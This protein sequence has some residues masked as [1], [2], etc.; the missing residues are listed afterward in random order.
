[1]HS[2]SNHASV[3]IG[4]VN[5]IGSR[6]TWDTHP[7]VAMKAF[8]EEFHIRG[9]PHLECEWC[10]STGWDSRL[11]QRGW[12]HSVTECLLLPL[13]CSPCSDGLCLQGTKV[14]PSSLKLRCVRCVVGARRKVTESRKLVLRSG[15]RA[16]VSLAVWSTGLYKVSGTIWRSV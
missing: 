6:I 4:F 9:K 2:G 7:G 13:L 10:H 15:A 11:G 1:M 8:L 5:S 16:V 12:M 14:N 3:V